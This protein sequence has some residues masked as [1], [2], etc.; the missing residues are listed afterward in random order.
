MRDAKIFL[1][2]FAI[3]FLAMYFVPSTNFPLNDEWVYFRS[4]QNFFETGAIS[5][6]GCTTSGILLISFGAVLTKLFGFSFALLRDL[7]IV[8]GSLSVAVSYLI[9]KEVTKKWK[10]SLLASLF[11]LANPIFYNLSHLFMTDV[12]FLFFLLL[13][14]Y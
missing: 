4:I 13:S 11:L 5:C 9:L 1:L 7:T 8:L 2:I 12:P 6:E 14:I 10:L 3:S